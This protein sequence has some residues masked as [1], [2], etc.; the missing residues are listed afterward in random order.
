LAVI[1]ICLKVTFVG[2]GTRFRLLVAFWIHM[3]IVEQISAVTVYGI[4]RL[5]AQC[6]V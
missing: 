6:S 5:L 1:E 4:R 2:P 3:S